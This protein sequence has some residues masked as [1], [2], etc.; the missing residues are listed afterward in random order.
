[1]SI[2]EVVRFVCDRPACKDK[3]MTFNEAV[4]HTETH[5]A[6][7]GIALLELDF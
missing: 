2:K 7:D 5:I 3:C 4:A 6:Q 1:M